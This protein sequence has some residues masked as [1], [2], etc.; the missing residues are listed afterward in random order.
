MYLVQRWMYWVDSERGVV[1][2]ASM[3]GSSHMVLH[4]SGVTTPTS[5]ALDRDAQTLYWIDSGRNRLESS[6]VDGSN[7][8]LLI[9]GSAALHKTHGMAVF[10]NKIYW[11]EQSNRMLHSISI[12]SP[13][14]I[15]NVWEF[16]T[17]DD[18]YE[19]AVV[20]PSEQPACELNTYVKNICSFP[21]YFPSS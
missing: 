17:N 1:E 11:T 14:L 5:L 12:S 21:A 2:R 10:Q 16:S 3:D 20:A 19:I 6:S 15:S 4:K 8:K 13:D 9:T 7:R 18:P